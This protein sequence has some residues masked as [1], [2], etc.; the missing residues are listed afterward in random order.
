MLP[1]SR[2]V[3]LPVDMLFRT[4]PWHHEVLV[5]VKATQEPMIVGRIRE[6]GLP[7]LD[8]AFH[9]RDGLVSPICYII[10]LIIRAIDNFDLLSLRIEMR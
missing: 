5:Q 3:G 8:Y 7:F 6:A 9:Q 2:P 4:Q 1:L 10:G